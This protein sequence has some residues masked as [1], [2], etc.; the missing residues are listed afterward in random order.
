[1]CKQVPF[2]KNARD[3]QGG[4]VV[5]SVAKLS[6]FELLYL[7]DWHLQSILLYQGILLSHFFRVCV[8]A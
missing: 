7:F 4:Q 6:G 5:S 2:K 8:I 3:S 1:M